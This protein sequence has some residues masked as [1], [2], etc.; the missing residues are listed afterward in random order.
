MGLSISRNAMLLGLFA[1]ICTGAIAVI[2]LVTKP[3][4]LKQEQI[5][6]QNNINELITIDRYDNN[7]IDTCFLVVDENLLGNN[8]PKQVYVATKNDQPVAALI[9]TSTLKGY[10]GEI[11]LLVGI[12]SHGEITGVRVNS[13]TETPG[14]GDKIQTN[15]SDWILSFDGKT[16]Q[17]EQ[18]KIWDV[19]KDGGNFDA[20]TGATITPRAVI[21]SVKDALIYFQKNKQQLFSTQPN[22]GEQ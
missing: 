2:N 22:C 15:K 4:I 14:L 20:F 18:D 9:Q 8:T 16:Y 11:K 3:L 7:I 5:A 13:H 21:H 19:K 1:V 12:D 10:S 6:L 17:A